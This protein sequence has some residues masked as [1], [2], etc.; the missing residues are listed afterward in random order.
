VYQLGFPASWMGAGAAI[1]AD[2]LAGYADGRQAGPILWGRAGEIV[3][4]EV[5]DC[6]L[7][8]S[9]RFPRISNLGKNIFA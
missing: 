2:A 7:G 4:L 1:I 9:H 6:H 8:A 3:L 5:Y